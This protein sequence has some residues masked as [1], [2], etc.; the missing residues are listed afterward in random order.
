MSEFFLNLAFLQYLQAQVAR[1]SGSDAARGPE[2]LGP[3]VLELVDAQVAQD[4]AAGPAL[5]LR[6]PLPPR[7]GSWN[8]ETGLSG[9]ARMHFYVEEWALGEC[10][11]LE[12][13][14]LP[15][16][17]PSQQGAISWS[18]LPKANEAARLQLNSS[19]ASQAWLDVPL[20]RNQITTL[21]PM[22]E[23]TTHC[24]FLLVPSKQLE[25]CDSAVLRV[26]SASSSEKAPYLSFPSGSAEDQDEGYSPHVPVSAISLGVFAALVRRRRL[27]RSSE[28]LSRERR[29]PSGRDQPEALEPAAAA[30][31]A[32][33]NEPAERSAHDRDSCDA[34]ELP[35]QGAVASLINADDISDQ[36]ERQDMSGEMFTTQDY[37]LPIRMVQTKFPE[38]QHMDI[39]RDSNSSSIHSFS[40]LS[41]GQHSRT[42]SSSREGA[43][44]I[45]D[46]HGT[47]LPVRSQQ[48]TGAGAADSPAARRLVPVR[49]YP[50][51]AREV[52]PVP[53]LRGPSSAAAAAPDLQEPGALENSLRGAYKL[54]DDSRLQAFELDQRLRKG[55]QSAPHLSRAGDKS[56]RYP[57]GH[58]AAPALS[59]LPPPRVK[60][61]TIVST[62]HGGLP[63]YMRSVS[64]PPA[65]SDSPVKPARPLHAPL[66]SF[67]QKTH[68]AMERQSSSAHWP[69]PAIVAN[70]S[71]SQRRSALP[72]A[73]IAA[74]AGAVGYPTSYSQEALHHS[75]GSIAPVSDETGTAGQLFASSRATARFTPSSP[76][77]GSG[78]VQY[79]SPAESSSGETLGSL[80]PMSFPTLEPVESRPTAWRSCPDFG[81]TYAT[82]STSSPPAPYYASSSY[83]ASPRSTAATLSAPYQPYYSNS[84]GR[85]VAWSSPAYEPASSSHA[86][87]APHHSTYSPYYSSSSSHSSRSYSAPYL[88]LHPWAGRNA[89]ASSSSASYLSS[90]RP[91]SRP[92]SLP[93]LP[94]IASSR[95]AFEPA[96]AV[97][98]A[99][100][101]SPAR[102]TSAG[103][104]VPAALLVATAPVT[105]HAARPVPRIIACSVEER[106]ICTCHL[107]GREYTEIGNLCRHLRKNHGVEPTPGA[108]RGRPSR[109]VQEERR[110]AQHELLAS[111]A[112]PTHNFF[113]SSTLGQRSQY[114]QHEPQDDDDDDG[115]GDGMEED[116]PPW[117]S[118]DDI[119]AVSA[120]RV[121]R[122]FHT[123]RYNDE[124]MAPCTPHGKTCFRAICTMA[125]QNFEKRFSSIT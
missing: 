29:S 118:G 23:T 53:G 7:N 6:W 91:S 85:A 22:T 108:R 116:D 99:A 44:E 100:P 8:P 110:R 57:L 86:P 35:K 73:T 97:A 42:P 111:G 24:D 114:E 39:A 28:D 59:P 34:P 15:Y 102:L 61:V 55:S 69:S 14:L 52:R 112:V 10:A 11:E 1:T 45:V 30:A 93:V 49:Q 124:R 84:S 106:K 46:T 123:E 60:E 115:D 92:T 94:S 3:Q 89:P 50:V 121:V 56:S 62:R 90:S 41:D 18:Q 16:S 43:Y 33:A 77:A 81:S 65:E 51:L 2:L 101:A 79:L 104:A 32:P 17:D 19:Q 26:A 72:P 83:S 107:C 87:T 96:R 125:A 40:T 71:S 58:P 31:N 88:P 82:V 120:S 113:P 27:G 103:P 9:G 12:L 68:S 117:I 67:T 48:A 76:Q 4:G 37:N 54:L 13:L 38:G 25:D 109:K 21:C 5:W 75:S 80:R 70:A 47:A 74:E 105:V 64:P 95:S 122:D 98:V 63:Y 119:T 36:L 78:H 66:P 20:K